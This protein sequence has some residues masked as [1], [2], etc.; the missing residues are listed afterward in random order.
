M[1]VYE[2]MVFIWLGVALVKS[3]LTVFAALSVIFEYERKKVKLNIV[4]T[5]LS[6]L[7]MV[8][9]AAVLIVIIWPFSLYLEKS[10][11]FK[12]PK[13]EMNDFYLKYMENFNK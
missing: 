3:T 5:I 13:K 10:D 1:S 11:F 8:L 6:A 7:V 4:S 12:L 2:W 9:G